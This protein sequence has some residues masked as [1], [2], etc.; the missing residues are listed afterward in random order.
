MTK[1]KDTTSVKTNP[2][3]QG[4]QLPRKVEYLRGT[5]KEMEG[6]DLKYQIRL[7]SI[8]HTRLA[9]D[10]DPGVKVESLQGAAKGRKLYE[11][12]IKSKDSVRCFYSLRDG[13]VLVA[14][15]FLK[16]REDQADKEINR[17]IQRLKDYEAQ[18]K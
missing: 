8:I 13:A 3:H 11:L 1:K 12:T 10:L 7:K 4:P 5:E 16:K 2:Q 18:K 6:L 17:A 9:H 15:V 14:V